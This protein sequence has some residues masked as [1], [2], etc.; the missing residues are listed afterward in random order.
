MNTKNNFFYE[1]YQKDG[2]FIIRNLIND[3]ILNNL[4]DEIFS[5]EK[6]VKYYDRKGTIRRIE[7][8]F[9]KGPNL[10][11]LN[12]LFQIKLKDIF[13]KDF[14]LFKDK[15]N[16]KPPNGEGFYAHYDGIFLW[17]DENFNLNKGWHIYADEFISVLVAIDECNLENGALELSQVNKGNFDVL[18]ENTKKDGTPNLSPN[19][20]KEIKFHPIIL[21]K[22][23]A[24]FFSSRCPHRSKKN[25]SKIHRKTIY[26]TYNFAKEG[27]NYDKYFADKIRSKNKT[28]M[29]LS[30]E[31]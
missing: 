2:F 21:D 13:N 22:G 29:S 3:D 15:Y 5:S 24:V 1:K 17:K 8:I 23:D 9:D 30:G 4:Y 7:K 16:A 19:Y 27:D 12:K 10:V 11:E 14:C 31:I 26:Y 28:S 25:L 6:T 18:Y 20:E